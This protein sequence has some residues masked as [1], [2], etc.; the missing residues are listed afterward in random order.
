MNWKLSDAVIQRMHD[1]L[2]M[3]TFDESPEEDTMIKK[4]LHCRFYQSRGRS[5]DFAGTIEK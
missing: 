5:A 2:M 1:I 3:I 4:Q